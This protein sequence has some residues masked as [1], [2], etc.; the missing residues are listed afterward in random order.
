[1][2]VLQGLTRLQLE[3]TIGYALGAIVES[4]LTEDGA[5]NGTSTVDTRWKGGTDDANGRWLHI[6]SGSN[7][8]TIVRITDDDGSGTLTHDDAGVQM[9]SGVT[10]LL[11]DEALRPDMVFNHINNAIISVT[12]KAYDY[13]EDT[14]LFCDGKQSRYDLPSTLAM[15]TRLQYR[16]YVQRSVIHSCDAA[17]DESVDNNFSPTADT[18]DKKE[19]ASANRFVITSGV[20]DGDFASDSIGSLDLRDYTHVEF[21]IKAITAVASNDLQLILSDAA[22]GANST[23]ALVI[24]ALS[25]DT[26]TRVRL[27]LA[28]PETDNAIIS[29][30]L[31]YNNNA[32]ANT[33]WLDDIV[34]THNDRDTWESVPRHMWGTEAEQRDLVLKHG[35]PGWIGY[36][37]LKIIGGD[38]PA[39][40]TS[41]SAVTEISERFIIN[42][43]CYTLLRT[44]PNH[45]MHKDR[46]DFQFEAE[47]ARSAIQVPAGIR[48]VG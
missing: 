15:V 32:G 47:L 17:F 31:K 45:P 43:A 28:N 46:K 42:Q 10:Y 7:S 1:M 14:S 21:W 18:E 23:E 33:I 16:S 48:K 30:A 38:E 4:S 13:R 20:S 27:A 9:Q 34:A 11:W 29:V 3:T 24:P 19:G 6:T 41:D 39:R 12:G 26:W 40:L 22:N 37:A 44:R 5:S 2:P 25:A 35:A 8:G 36:A